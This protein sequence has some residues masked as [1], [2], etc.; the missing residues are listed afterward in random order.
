MFMFVILYTSAGDMT[1]KKI[2]FRRAPRSSDNISFFAKNW[3]DGVMIFKV[4]LISLAPGLTGFKIF[5]KVG[6]E[7]RILVL[8]GSIK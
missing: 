6:C 4:F 3:L 7:A 2:K 1:N 5:F 8:K